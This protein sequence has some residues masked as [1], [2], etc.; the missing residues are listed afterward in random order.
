VANKYNIMSVLNKL[1]GRM[2]GYNALTKGP[3]KEERVKVEPV[4]ELTPEGVD[5]SMVETKPKKVDLSRAKQMAES[6]QAKKE[7]PQAYEETDRMR[8]TD[9]KIAQAKES[10]KKGSFWSSYATKEERLKDRKKRQVGR[11]ERK[12][13]RKEAK[14]GKISKEQKR[15]KIKASRIKQKP[16]GKQKGDV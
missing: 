9:E 15:D 6:T 2:S 3:R 12:E 11:A 14:Q 7:E 1:K 8:V 4:S 5:M 16:T 10:G 13:I